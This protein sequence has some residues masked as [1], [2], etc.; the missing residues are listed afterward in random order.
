M[1]AISNDWLPALRPE[2]GKPYYREL[3]SFI[4]QEYAT[5]TVYPP[6]DFAQRH[7]EQMAADETGD[8]VPASRFSWS[9]AINSSSTIKA[10][11]IHRR[12]FMMR[13]DTSRPKAAGSPKIPSLAHICLYRGKL[14]PC[15]AGVYT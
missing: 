5:R 6:A 10:F 12:F 13:W 7:P 14:Y 11:M 8:I 3:Y 1:A 4:N 9:W 2:F 15:I